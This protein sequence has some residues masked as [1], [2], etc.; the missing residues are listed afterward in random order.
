MQPALPAEKE[1]LKVQG[2]EADADAAAPEKK[3]VI[4]D[5]EDD[6]AD[7]KADAEPAD[8]GL[9]EE[10]GAQAKTKLEK[11]EPTETA[12]AGLEVEIGAQAQIKLEKDESDELAEPTSTIKLPAE[13]WFA[14]QR[15][16]LQKSG[17]LIRDVISFL[18]SEL[19]EEGVMELGDARVSE[20][21]KKHTPVGMFPINISPTYEVISDYGYINV[22]LQVFLW[23][24]IIHSD[25]D[26]PF[27]ER[28]VINLNLP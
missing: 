18:K 22:L 23:R 16:H 7:D 3:L 27:Y 24:K 25:Y 14:A 10:I 8:A 12:N 9:E 5:K 4:D 28:I 17:K 2:E 20:L 11:D 1:E 26:L 19:R 21:I 6:K 15:A 13:P